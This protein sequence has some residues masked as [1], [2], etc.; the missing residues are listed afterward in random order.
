[1]TD[2]YVMASGKRHPNKMA[3]EKWKNERKIYDSVE[4]LRP[5][6]EGSSS[7]TKEN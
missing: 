1:M 5:L 3:I 6:I 4:N 2:H 7:K